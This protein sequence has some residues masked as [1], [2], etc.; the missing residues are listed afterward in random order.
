VLRTRRPLPP[1]SGWRLRDG[2]ARTG[3]SRL[4]VALHPFHEVGLSDRLFHGP[5]ERRLREH[6][7]PVLG[8]LP[9]SDRDLHSREIGVLNP[10]AETFPADGRGAFRHGECGP[11]AVQSYDDTAAAGEVK[12]RVERRGLCGDIFL[13]GTPLGPRMGDV[14]E[15]TPAI[16][17]IRVSW[18]LRWEPEFG[19][20]GSRVRVER[21]VFP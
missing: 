3:R 21:G 4:S 15:E 19:M 2:S 18:F 20:I 17:W 11:R 5:F 13:V 7:D 8:P 6:R 9:V 16:R 14:K 1:R 10:E 12:G